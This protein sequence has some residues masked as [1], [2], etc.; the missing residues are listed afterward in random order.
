MRT[1]GDF[2]INFN[3]YVMLCLDRQ[4]VQKK[5]WASSGSSGLLV[6]ALMVV[7]IVLIVGDIIFLLTATRRESL[8]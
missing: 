5:L 6:T 1:A 8:P 7:V 2:V 4:L 3:V